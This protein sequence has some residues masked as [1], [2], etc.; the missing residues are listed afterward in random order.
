QVADDNALVLH[1]EIEGIRVL[2]LSDLAKRGQNVLLQRHADL[3]A[4]IVISGVPPS[5]EPLSDGLL[6]TIRPEVIVVTDSLY[7]ATARASQRLR[8]RLGSQAWRVFYTSDAGAITVVLR[9]NSWI[10]QNATG[11]ELHRGT[12][13]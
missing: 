11:E 9:R 8:D 7:P 12:R 6:E 2:L 1:A 3:R 13:R 5:S 10:L 4:D